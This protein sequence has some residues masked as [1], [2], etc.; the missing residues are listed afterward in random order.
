[1]EK[2]QK[3]EYIIKLFLSVLVIFAAIAYTLVDT[4]YIY[5]DLEP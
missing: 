5:T 2:T 1:M 4:V 3:R